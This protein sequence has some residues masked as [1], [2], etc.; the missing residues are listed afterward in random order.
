MGEGRERLVYEVVRR[1]ERGEGIRAIARGLDIDRKTVRRILKEMAERRA[2]GDDALARERPRSRTPKPS[3]LDRYEKDIARIVAEFPDI[4]A[5]RLHEELTALGFRGG[6][7]IVREHLNALQPAKRAQVHELVVTSVGRQAQADWSP[8][9][10]TDQT[11]IYCFSSVL[12][13]CRALAAR[14]T[15]DMRQPTVFRMLRRT[16]DA[17][18][19]VPAEIVFDSMAGIVDG[20]DFDRPI[21]NL[22]A[23][24]FAAY[25]GFAIHVAPRADGAYK[26]K[27]ERRYRFMEESLFNGRKFHTLD[28]ANQTL[29]WWLEHK[30]NSRKH[31]HLRRPIA[32]LHAEERAVLR[33]LP[34]HPYDDR[35]MA[36]RL[37]DSYGYVAFDGNH[38]R[39]PPERVGQW[40]YVRATEDSVQIVVAPVT[41]AATHPRAPRNAGRF[42]P[43][44]E[45][46]RPRR[47]PLNEILACFESWGPTAMKYAEAIRARSR[48]AGKELGHVLGLRTNWAA[49]D[50]L[51]AIE[52]AYHHAAFGPR[53]L[54]RILAARAK[55]RTLDDHLADSARQRIQRA[56]AEAPVE[57]RGLAAYARLLA[58]PATPNGASRE[59]PD[60]DDPQDDSQ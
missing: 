48:Y 57:Q 10:L 3:K 24:D 12:S 38:Y 49:E 44:P 39:A 56:L 37:V 31:P 18:G 8:Y 28:E 59:C 16:F 52:H 54:E 17:H 55:P 34:S 42:E 60:A 29:D 7:T 40:V 22:R 9:A 27:V 19:G 35:E 11:P 1:Q 23:V 51:R 45:V 25:Y 47:R 14:F 30:A 50:V 53:D 21:L 13:Y 26:G 43:P 15:L 36:H 6:Y 33:P 2:S 58:G 4:R 5:T 46:D 41:I 32:E 20:W